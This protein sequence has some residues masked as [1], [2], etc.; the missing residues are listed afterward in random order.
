MDGL[1]VSEGVVIPA[2]EIRFRFARSGGPGGQNVNKVESRVE[3][4]FDLAASSAFS[5]A[6][7][8]RLRSAL[9]TK[10]DDDGVLQIVVQESR[11]Q[12]QNR[13]TA[14]A[15]LAETIRVALIPRKRRVATKPSRGSKEERV[16]SKKKRGEIKRN[17]GRISD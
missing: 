2:R 9:R 4:L 5:D 12:W 17:R 11:S 1:E 6:Q 7:R 16:R 14:L 15:R 3:L 8:H 10:L 13:E